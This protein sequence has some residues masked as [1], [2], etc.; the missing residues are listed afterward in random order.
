MQIKKGQD[1]IVFVFP[2][3]RIVIKLPIIHVFLAFCPE[4]FRVAKEKGV[5]LEYLKRHLTYRLEILGGFWGL[6][7][8]GLIANWSEFCFYR[9]TRNPFLQPTYFS[10]FGFLNIQRYD[11]PCQMKDL[12]LWR[13]FCALTG[14]EV[15][16]D[17]HHFRESHNFSLHN[18]KLRILDYGDRRTQKIVLKQG[19]KI[20][21]FFNPAHT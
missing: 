3:L 5:A 15:K 14:N 1:R 17:P 11:E 12:N 10:L 8:R 20:A 6:L 2:S 21:E 9:K 13:H 16:N 7:L 4:F 19:E 18:G